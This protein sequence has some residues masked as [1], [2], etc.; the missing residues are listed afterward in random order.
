MPQLPHAELPHAA[1]STGCNS[2]TPQ[3]LHTATVTHCHSH[4]PPLPHIANPTHRHTHTTPLPP[5]ATPTKSN[6]QA[7]K[8][9]HNAT[10]TQ[11]ILILSSH[12][13][14]LTRSKFG[15]ATAPSRKE[16][17]T[18]T[19]K[20]ERPERLPEEEANEARERITTQRCMYLI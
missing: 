14:L 1:T 10:P 16:K 5:N 13:M 19:G 4:K 18:Y 20:N 2:H 6:F 9:P 8:P 12:Q 15:R 11:A 7:T 17:G 3:I